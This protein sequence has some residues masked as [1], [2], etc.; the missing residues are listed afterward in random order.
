MSVIAAPRSNVSGTIDT[1]IALRHFL[2]R[3][4]TVPVPGPAARNENRKPCGLPLAKDI[5]DI[6]DLVGIARTRFCRDAVGD[7]RFYHDLKFCG[8]RP[9]HD[10]RIRVLGHINHLAIEH[11]KRTRAKAAMAVLAG[12]R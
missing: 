11:A 10:T 2:D 7:P 3:R 5:E 8:R 1:T 9:R 4:A 12:G 6:C